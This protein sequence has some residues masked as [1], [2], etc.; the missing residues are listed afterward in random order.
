MRNS[1]K[2]LIF[3]VIIAGGLFACQVE[4]VTPTPNYQQ[5]AVEDTTDNN[6]ENDGGGGDGDDEEP[7]IQD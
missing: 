6:P 7:I 3:A 5:V 1:L 2:T 4:E